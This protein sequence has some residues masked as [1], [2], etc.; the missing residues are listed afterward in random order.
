MP[1]T[2]A[3]HFSLDNHAHRVTQAVQPEELRDILGLI[4]RE[5][6]M[7]NTGSRVERTGFEAATNYELQLAFYHTANEMVRR[8]H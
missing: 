1:L 5:I 6:S 8:M 3:H 7:R 4:F 2:P